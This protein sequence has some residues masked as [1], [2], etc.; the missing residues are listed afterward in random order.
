M[1]KK[2]L[3]FGILL[4]ILMG[5]FVPVY[6]AHA[7]LVPIAADL[8]TGGGATKAVAKATLGP[9]V[10]GLFEGIAQWMMMISSLVLRFSGMI[11]DWVIKF[12]IVDMANNIGGSTG[13]GASI[14]TAWATLRD[15][16]NICFIFV[17][18]FAAFKAMF[19]LSFGSIGT[20]IRNIIIVALLI[21]F[22]LFFSKVVI[23][24]SN[25]V[26]VGFYNSIASSQSSLGTSNFTGISAGY[27][28]M[29]GVQTFYGSEILKGN[30]DPTQMLT[31]G[32]MSSVF[33]LITAVILL[34]AGIMLAARFIILILIMILSPVALIAYI[35]PGMKNQF[36]K[37]KD[38]LIDQSFFAPLYF[39]LTWVVFKLGNSLI[40]TLKA[41]AGMPPQ[42][43]S[44]ANM[45]N[46]P[47]GS[48]AIIVNFVLMIGFS[49]AALIFAKQM[50]VKT[51]GFK[52]ISG[53]IGV[54]A[55]G[56]AAWAGR[57]SLGQIGTAWSKNANLQEAANKERTGFGRITGGLS[58]L[59]L[60]A[61]Q[62]ASNATFDARNAKIP[63]SVIGDAI[64]GTVG[65]TTYG[66]KL[67]LNDVNI[68][69]VPVSALGIDTGIMGKGDTKGYKD[70]KAESDKRIREREATAKSE[71]DLAKAQIAVKDG[72]KATK[73]SP[74]YDAM[75][76]ALTKLS[77]K[78]IEALVA[79]NKKLLDSQNFANAISVKQLD[80]LNKS[81]QFSSTEKDGLKSLRFKNI[82]IG[83]VAGATVAQ[84]DAMEQSISDMSDKE[85]EILVGS[86]KELLKNRNF[87][88][89]ISTKQ[90]E[91]LNKS[92][93]FTESEKT[94]LKNTR[95]AEI[96]A[97]M[98]PSHKTPDTLKLVKGAIKGLTDS[99][100]EM[101]DPSY[102]KDPD[103]VSQLR[104]G[105]AESITKSSKFTASQ[106]QALKDG[107]NKP[108]TDALAAG[109]IAGIQAAIR[110]VDYKTLVGY[111]NIPG[112]GGLAI[113]L[114]PAVLPTYNAKIL[115]KMADEMNDEDKLTLKSAI[116]KGG[117][118]TT[119]NWLKDPDKGGTFFV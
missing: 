74:A 42:N 115:T 78:E 13:I 30:L 89:T 119:I 12:T 48:V 106:K 104:S 10:D 4:V 91:S 88:D 28:N 105:Q 44:F 1:N 112:R 17:L 107:R 73:G 29:L 101:I 58:R 96:N 94:N 56:G 64:Q 24:A 109:N 66:K 19:E 53:G 36:D 57:K 108:L 20:T 46:D 81:E 93:Q 85:I 67:G 70:T 3:T 52:Q 47:N 9:L 6:T 83:T 99:E 40:A 11:F 98:D 2:F 92:D 5:I 38:A 16:A 61:S 55:A 39:A 43:P 62:K 7:Q 51:A 71:Y 100:L 63:T 8:L 111:M 69:S 50:A 80:I 90:L 18:L 60:Y 82:N 33:M 103:F 116:E 114:D 68:P 77:D 37:W 79:S 86:N 27:M 110:K 25:I 21:N 54:V 15:V 22:S 102:L 35:I 14:T 72:I 113:A 87:T 34:I 32:F 59:G 95:F 26:S 118:P 75:E 97:A 117:N 41:Q 45:L 76:K 49:I 31:F 84:R 65:R 23:D